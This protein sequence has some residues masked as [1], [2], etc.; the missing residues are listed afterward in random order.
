MTRRCDDSEACLRIS[1]FGC[2][3]HL[4]KL[5]GGGSPRHIHELLAPLLD[6]SKRDRLKEIL[7]TISALA[8]YRGAFTVVNAGLL[9]A[10]KSSLFNALLEAPERFA[11]G[12]VRTTTASQARPSAF[13]LLIDTPGLDASDVDTEEAWLALKAADLVLFVHGMECGEFDRI[14]TA[15][16]SRLVTE[17]GSAEAFSRRVIPVFQKADCL[18]DEE[19]ERAMAKCLDSWTGTTGVRPAASFVTSSMRLMR[20]CGETDTGK[21]RLWKTASGV[22]ALAAWLTERHEAWKAREPVRLADRLDEAFQELIRLIDDRI[23]ELDMFLGMVRR[24]DR[25]RINRIETELGE[26]HTVLATT[27]AGW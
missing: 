2:C 12:S 15:F 4:K 23:G 20:A 3:S 21:S 10:G 9:K 7:E 13:G 1:Y 16:L 18:S 24:A 8:R 6:E 25:D 27:N 26:L 11:T 5:L 17:M 22:P 19:R 14:E